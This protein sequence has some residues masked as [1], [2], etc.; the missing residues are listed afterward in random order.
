MRYIMLVLLLLNIVILGCGSDNKI[1]KTV[2]KVQEKDISKIIIAEIINNPELVRN[3]ETIPD[4][5]D[6][7]I[8]YSTYMALKAETG[9]SFDPDICNKIKPEDKDNC[10]LYLAA[11]KVN[12][13]K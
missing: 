13:L 6:K 4:L 10:N 3:C 9:E 2:E 8:C 11:V 12:K 7:Q 1:A 5:V